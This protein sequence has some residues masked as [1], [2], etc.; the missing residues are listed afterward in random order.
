MIN[1]AA[2]AADITLNTI[3]S[4]RIPYQQARDLHTWLPLICRAVYRS[5]SLHWNRRFVKCQGRFLLAVVMRPRVFVLMIIMVRRDP[6]PACS[7]APDE[8]TTVQPTHTAGMRCAPRQFHR[9]SSLCSLVRVIKWRV[10]SQVSRMKE[11]HSIS[12]SRR[13]ESHI[14]AERCVIGLVVNWRMHASRLYVKHA[15]SA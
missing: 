15:Y 14:S 9:V 2:A 4:L 10:W 1:F 12:W 8:T 3:P 13:D 11:A 5:E 6:A 7:A